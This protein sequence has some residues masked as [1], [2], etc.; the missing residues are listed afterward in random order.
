[1]RERIEKVKSRTPAV[2]TG[3]TGR[4]VQTM[5]GLTQ[6][7]VAGHGEG[8]EGSQLEESDDSR[9]ALTEPR[10]LL[11]GGWMTYASLCG[12]VWRCV[13][14]AVMKPRQRGGADCTEAAGWRAVRS[15]A[16]RR[17]ASGGHVGPGMVR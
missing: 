5:R 8:D 11:A 15:S 17:V 6:H 4:K 9:C 7:D 3:Y 1:M 16:D 14:H 12:G 13:Y 10:S 2:P